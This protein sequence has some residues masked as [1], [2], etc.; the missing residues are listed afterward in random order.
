MSNQCL[1][2]LM[3]HPMSFSP[4]KQSGVLVDNAKHYQ[5]M[6]GCVFP[7]FPC[8]AFCMLHIFHI[9]QRCGVLCVTRVFPKGVHVQL[10]GWPWNGEGVQGCAGT[11]RWGSSNQG[12]VEC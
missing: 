7:L 4:A 11:Q 2:H 6:V 8:F 9:G 5:R 12:K 1:R 3:W 10:D